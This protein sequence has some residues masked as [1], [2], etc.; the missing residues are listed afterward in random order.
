MGHNLALHANGQVTGWGGQHPGPGA[1]VPDGLAKV[2]AIAA[3][4]GYS[5]ALQRNGRITAWVHSRTFRYVPAPTTKGDDLQP[6]TA[7]DLRQIRARD[8]ARLAVGS[9]AMA[10]CSLRRRCIEKGDEV[11]A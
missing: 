2:T 1:D 6:L 9:A 10:S 8:R 4:G 11:G 7:R 3:G 5:L